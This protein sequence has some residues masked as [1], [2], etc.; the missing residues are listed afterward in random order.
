MKD[1]TT[2]E[3]VSFLKRR[4][5]P[6]PGV[7]NRW[8][9]VYRPY[10]CPFDTLLGYMPEGQAVLD[11]GCGGGGFLQLVAE[12]RMP[13][14]VA[15]LETKT[16]LTVAAR[17]Q[18][19]TSF[20]RIPSRFE[21]YDGITLPGWTEEYDYV[22]LIDVLHHVPWHQQRPMLESILSL[23]KRGA[24]LVIKDIDAGERMWCL[25]N[26]IH[27]LIVAGELPREVRAEDLR[28]QLRTIGFLIRDFSTQRLYVYP[29]F[30]IVCEKL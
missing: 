19:E 14:A 29:H 7:F 2:R 5:C 16:Q 3:L 8:K 17:D 23:M 11:I 13:I 6:S 21:T 24:K 10:I 15:G 9:M 27:D 18:F 30:I 4:N 12:Y 28:E 1:V 20:S 22:F 25:F 26:K